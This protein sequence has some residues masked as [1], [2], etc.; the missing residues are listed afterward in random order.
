MPS[1]LPNKPM[2]KHWS[3]ESCTRQCEVQYDFQ[4][5]TNI[6]QKKC[7]FLFQNLFMIRS[8][9]VWTNFGLELCIFTL[10]SVLYFFPV[11]A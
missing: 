3:R 1:N 9:Q 10:G 11:S 8:T 5:L 4:M 2:R 6:L 7:L